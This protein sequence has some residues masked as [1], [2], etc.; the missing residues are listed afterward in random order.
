MADKMQKIRVVEE[1]IYGANGPV[2]VGSEFEITGEMPRGWKSKCVVIGETDEDAEP[3]QN[4]EEPNF[5]IMNKD[6]LRDFAELNDIDV[7]GRWSED[8][9]REAIVNAVA[10]TQ[11]NV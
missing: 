10:E 9:I 6:E 4:D 3:V 7:D 2:P 8:Q 5:D 11:N 1:G